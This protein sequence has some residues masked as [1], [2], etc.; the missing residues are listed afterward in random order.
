MGLPAG[1]LAND[2]PF[3][4]EAPMEVSVNYT[5]DKSP[6]VFNQEEMISRSEIPGIVQQAIKQSYAYMSSRLRNH[7]NER[8]KL[9]L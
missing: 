2:M 1:K 6:L 3:A 4:T 9:G 7:P 5:S 8:R